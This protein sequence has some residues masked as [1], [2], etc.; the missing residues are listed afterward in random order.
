[1][2]C[3]VAGLVRLPRYIERARSH[4]TDG[5]RRVLDQLVQIQLGRIFDALFG[6]CDATRASSTM[7]DRSCRGIV[8]MTANT[9]EGFPYGF[10]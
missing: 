3:G 6:R 9:L 7:I 10:R 5:E 2:L 4:V 1:M 8:D